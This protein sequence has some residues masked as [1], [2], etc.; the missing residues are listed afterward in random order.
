MAISAATPSVIDETNSKSLWRLARLSR[1]AIFQIQDDDECN[2]KVSKEIGIAKAR[3]SQEQ[4]SPYQKGA[5]R[6]ARGLSVR[7]S[8]AHQDNE[9]GATAVASPPPPFS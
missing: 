5:A 6:S 1:Q 3:R 8:Q 2:I 7:L 9:G 4:Y